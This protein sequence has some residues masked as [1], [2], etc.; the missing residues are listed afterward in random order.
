[1]AVK[2]YSLQQLGPGYKLSANFTLGEFACKDGSDTVLVDEA[3]VS[4]LQK[5]REHFKLPVTINSAYRTEAYNRKVGG[6]VGSQHSKGTAADTV[7]KGVTPLVVAQYAESVGAGGVG[8]Y[9][10]GQGNFTHIDTR[11]VKYRWEY[12][13]GK[14]VAVKG[15]GA[16]VVSDHALVVQQRAGLENSTMA[17]LQEY[18]FSKEL[19][20]KLAEAIN[21]KAAKAAGQNSAARVQAAAGLE[22]STIAY[23]CQYKYGD[24]LLDK[25]AA[26]M[27]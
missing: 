20:E 12:R 18:R 27:K 16:Q 22:D 14:E 2:T 11:A 13:S 5:I 9:P 25:L 10:A 15:F 6:A 8:H 23:L 7:V 1:M 24:A 17:Y 4:F 19:L 26:A 3:L 21:K